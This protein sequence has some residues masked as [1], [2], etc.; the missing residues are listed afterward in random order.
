[1]LDY[2][3]TG[4]KLL[5]LAG[6]FVLVFG[7]IYLGV[8]FWPFLIGIVLAVILEKPVETI[9]KKTRI[10]RKIVGL[11]AVI[12]TFIILGALIALA[13]TSLVNEAITLSTK[14]P[15]IYENLRIEYKTVYTSITELLDRTPTAV[16]ESIYNIGLNILSKLATLTTKLA[17]AIINFIMFVPNILI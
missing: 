16:S 14:I 17:N 12:L 6:V 3:K 10:P 2:K 4:T 1:M 5:A 15:N 7:V 11:I 13:I 9:V 8:Y